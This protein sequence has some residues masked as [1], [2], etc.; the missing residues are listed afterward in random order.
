[1]VY[2]ISPS[3]MREYNEKEISLYNSCISEVKNYFSGVIEVKN[4]M[5]IPQVIR[6]LNENSILIFLN[7]ESITQNRDLIRL[8]EKAKKVN[9]EI[10]PIAIDKDKRIPIDNVSTKQ[11]FDV[12]DQLRVRG[13]NEYY[14]EVIG[15]VL[16]RKIISRV[17]PTLYNEKKIFFISHR[18]IDGEEI[19]AKLCDRLEI[20]FRES[21]IFRDVACVEVG[22]NAQNEIDKYLSKSDVLIFLHTD[23]ASES[24]WIKKELIYA[25]IN[26]IPV[27]WINIDNAN[28]DNLVIKPTDKPH[29]ECSSLD[30][31]D[32]HKLIKISDEIIEKCYQLSM[33]CMNEVYDQIN[34][35]EEFCRSRNIDFNEEDKVNLIYSF[36]LPRKGYNYPQRDI[37]HYVQYFGRRCLEDDFINIRQFLK[38]KEFNNIPLYDSAILLSNKIQIRNIKDNIVEENFKDFNLFAKKAGS[39]KHKVDNGEI[40]LSGAF[41]EDDMLHKQAL[42]DALCIFAK[43]I[44]NNDFILTF[45]AHPT[46]QNLIFEIG[47]VYRPNDYRQKVNMY[48]SKYF[49]SFYDLNELK[50]NASIFETEV[51]SKDSRNLNLTELRNKMISNRKSIKALIC[52]GGVIRDGD[53]LNGIDEEIML[54]RKH[55]IPVFLIGTVGGRSSEIAIKNIKENKWASFNNESEKFNEELAFNIDYR[56]L[57]NK[58]L[59]SIKN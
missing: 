29:I 5:V 51:V 30:F 20:Q 56:Y 12:Y 39:Q 48:I 26:N 49:K 6:E 28:C 55:N 15:K 10:W 53:N 43:E 52:L 42:K 23:K 21:E 17:L 57:A 18:R 1:M 9:C 45:G 3:L 7:N 36:R 2:F 4:L 46:F 41:N 33:N 40:I 14:I 35:F 31:L 19:A 58:I 44:L 24:E 50:L 32:E 16:A 59:E 38:D 25:V 27:L 54:A 8:L 47:K 22:Q 13:M 11:S 34:T 37:K